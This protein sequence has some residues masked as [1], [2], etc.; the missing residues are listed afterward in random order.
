MSWM[1]MVGCGAVLAPAFVCWILTW[2]GALD[3]RRP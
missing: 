3:E 1:D 2:L